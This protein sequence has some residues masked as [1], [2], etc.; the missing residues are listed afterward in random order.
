MTLQT[1][2]IQSAQGT[3]PVLLGDSIV[4]DIVSH[5]H[6]LGILEGRTVFIVSDTHLEA[7]GHVQALKHRLRTAGYQ[8][9][10]SVVTAGDESKNVS[11]L[12][13]LYEAMIEAGVRR[14]S[15]VVALGGGVIGDLAGFA[16]ATFLRG[17]TFIQMPTT[18]LAHDSSLGGKTGINL[19]QGKNLVGAYYPPR[20]VLYDVSYLSTL[21]NREWRNGMAEVIKHGILGDASLFE[22][23]EEHPSQMYSGPSASIALLTQAMSVK[24]KIVEQDEHE[25]GL[26]MLLNIGH[27]VGHAVEKLSQYALGHGEA[28]S[29]GMVV[30]NQL[31]VHR[32]LLSEVDCR[33][34]CTVLAAHGL[35]TQLPEQSFAEVSA[36]MG[37]DKKHL[38]QG[39]TF[40]LPTEIGQA[41]VVRDVTPAEVERAWNAIRDCAN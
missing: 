18:L 41:T 25:T 10:V 13:F 30:E 17:V 38:N 5:L 32:G 23:L 21:P 33:R 20:A 40:A 3:Y 28:I 34:I 12:C 4:E 31:A 2:T 15:V 11:T 26:R 1:L 16:A 35:P 8:I 6:S 27:T 24:V 7:L 14:D 36:L 37:V 39:W 29:I 22:K 9:G 19:P